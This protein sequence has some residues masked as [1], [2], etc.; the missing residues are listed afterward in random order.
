MVAMLRQLPVF[1]VQSIA[2]IEQILGAV[3]CFF[4]RCS[5]AQAANSRLRM[6]SSRA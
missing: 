4:H 3:C 5:A 2:K 6:A 1:A